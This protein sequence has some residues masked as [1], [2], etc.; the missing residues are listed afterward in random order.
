MEIKN[1]QTGFFEEKPGV[2]SSTRL[3]SFLLLL[4]FMV[5]NFYAL[6]MEQGMTLDLQMFDFILLI[7]IFAP[8]YLHKVAELKDFTAMR[9]KEVESKQPKDE[10]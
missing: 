4:F 3:Y 9:N 10:K 5:F 1:K 8:K 6:N 7:A 2:K